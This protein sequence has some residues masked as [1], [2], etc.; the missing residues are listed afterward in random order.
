MEFI[1]KNK[2]LFLLILCAAY[3]LTLSVGHIANIYIDVGREIYY[4][5]AILEGKVLY[6]D[7]FCI[8][9]PFSYLFNALLYKIFGAELS[10][11]Y[12]AG[13]V[14]ALSIVSLIYLISRKFLSNFISIVIAIF[15]IIT[16]C[17]ATRIFN[18]TLPYSYAVLYG[19]VCF[20]ISLWFLISFLENK[21]EKKLI[22]SS[23][24]AGL[25]VINKY[26]FFLYFIPLTVVILK[27]KNIKLILKSYA[28]FFI[29]CIIPFII[30]FI[31][32]ITF[33]DLF[34]TVKAIKDFTATNAMT[35]FYKTQ[36]VYYTNNVWMGWLN[37]I[38]TYILY[39]VF[40]IPGVFIF[41]KKNIFLKITG[42]VLVTA[43]ILFGIFNIRQTD[44]LFLTFLTTV[45]FILRFK[46]NSY[47]EN[48]LI[49]SIILIS[50]KSVWGLSHVNYGLYYAS[51]VLISFFIILKNN[52]NK[53]LVH[54]ICF[55]VIAGAL[56]FLS[57][58]LSWIYNMNGEIITNK[59]KILTVNDWGKVTG[60]LIEYIDSIEEDNPFIVVL[61]E[62]L[63]VNFLT[64]KQ[65]KTEG[66]Y[67]SL[68]PLYTEGFG[69]DVIIEHYK[70]IMPDYFIITNMSTGSYEKGEICN[71]YAQRFCNFVLDNYIPIK[72]FEDDNAKIVVFYK[73]GEL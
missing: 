31:Q 68:I 73:G 32:G 7:L 12:L 61:P 21:D 58:N 70:K 67:N 10:T 41:Y 64:A 46:K 42:I 28:G 65:H 26:D 33:A 19:L 34:N 66:F 17:L 5:E 54:S 16:G 72:R 38:S 14:C 35:V 45:I 69:E 53:K 37:I 56:S 62:G 40:I 20:L 30:L 39:L 36:G 27:T 24:F 13:S 43:G 49:S 18:F 57:I 60:E 23:V 22:L 48:I 3:C 4:P 2:T 9:G 59:G 25:S 63:I 15:T 50:L 6:K 52:L 55:V 51:S 29:T 47:I 11:L 71:T 8:Y 1:K 44:Y